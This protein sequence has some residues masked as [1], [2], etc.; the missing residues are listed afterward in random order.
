MSLKK[1]LLFIFL[2]LWWAIFS[3][4]S[5]CAG[6]NTSP[7]ADTS[8]RF[9]R[10]IWRASWRPAVNRE[11]REAT[12]PRRRRRRRVLSSREMEFFSGI[13]KISLRSNYTKTT[14]HAYIHMYACVRKEWIEEWLNDKRWLPIWRA[15]K[16]T[17]WIFRNNLKKLKLWNRPV[18]FKIINEKNSKKCPARLKQ[19]G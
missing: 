18:S 11:E 9:L 19:N 3:D 2:V 13:G 4:L 1:A 15:L 17:F 8:P 7:T 16:E 5:F 10:L 14:V 12:I 6:K